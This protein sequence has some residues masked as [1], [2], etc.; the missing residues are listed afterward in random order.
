[1]KK[2]INDIDD[3]NSINIVDSEIEIRECTVQSNVGYRGQYSF[4]VA[5]CGFH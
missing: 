4:W 5:K 3:A 1:M 2:I